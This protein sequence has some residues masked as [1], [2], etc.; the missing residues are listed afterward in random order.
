MAT[1][2]EHLNRVVGMSR[3]LIRPSVRCHNLASH[4]LG[5]VLRGL[6][7]DFDSQYGYRPWLVESFVET[8]HFAGTCYQAANWVEIGQ[9]RGRGRQDRARMKDMTVK[10]IYVYFLEPDFRARM[11]I[12]R[13]IAPPPLVARDITEGL[14][15]DEW[16]N[17]EF[18]GAALENL[19]LSRR[20]IDS[21]RAQGAMPGRAFC[22][23]AQGDCP[24]IK[25][26]YRMID[27]PAESKVSTEAI[28][29]PPP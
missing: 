9:T 17:N 4:V 12:G 20:L 13:P 14:D 5:M 2:R 26:Y 10:A 27:K 19:H 22:A 6:A 23:V 25:G 29:A 18:G 16:A 11:K 24:A 21:A 1:R 15:G 3:F 28:L 7:Q 8:D